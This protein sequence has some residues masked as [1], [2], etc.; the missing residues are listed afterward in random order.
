MDRDGPTRFQITRDSIYDEEIMKETKVE[1]K[2]RIRNLLRNHM[3]EELK[4]AQK[5]QSKISNISYKTFK[6]QDYLKTHMMNNHEVA[7]LFALRSRTSSYF[8]AN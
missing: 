2:L 3:F 5:E 8:K 1:F 7:L 4:R 6:V